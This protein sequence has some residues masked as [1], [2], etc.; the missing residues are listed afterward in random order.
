MAI[1]AF[2]FGVWLVSGGGNLKK[3][4]KEPLVGATILGAIFLYNGWQTPRFL[5]ATLELI[6]QMA[7]PLMLITLGVAISR[8]KPQDLSKAS[9]YSALK[10]VVCFLCCLPAF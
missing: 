9:I 5:T 3:V 8:L 4:L 10:F 1:Y 2:T 6:G 7:I